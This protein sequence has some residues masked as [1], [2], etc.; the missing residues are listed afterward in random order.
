M[1]PRPSGGLRWRTWAICIILVTLALVPVKV[2]FVRELLAAEL[3]FLLAFVFL[4]ALGGLCYLLAIAGERSHL[5]IK[6]EAGA[7]TR[8]WMAGEPEASIGQHT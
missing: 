4:S 3:L 8:T 7:P 6:Q 2:Y 1:R 5:F